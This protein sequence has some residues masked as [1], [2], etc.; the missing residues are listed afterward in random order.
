[1]NFLTSLNLNTFLAFSKLMLAALESQSCPEESRK[2]AC[3][4]P[5]GAASRWRGS[6]ALPGRFCR[7]SM[8]LGQPP[9]QPL[10]YCVSGLPG[11]EVVKGTKPAH[12]PP[13]FP[14]QMIMSRRGAAVWTDSEPIPTP[15]GTM[16]MLPLFLPFSSLLRKTDISLSS[17]S[18]SRAFQ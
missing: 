16:M 14:F 17:H 6:P 13:S 9:L 15:I 10:M 2:N 1:M 4:L 12:R 11:E 18:W 7:A 5:P 8:P 3:P